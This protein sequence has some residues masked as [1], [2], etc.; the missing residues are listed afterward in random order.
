[1]HAVSEWS[2]ASVVALQALLEGGNASGQAP[3]EQAV[4]LCCV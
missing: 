4:F 2:V 1:M 3:L